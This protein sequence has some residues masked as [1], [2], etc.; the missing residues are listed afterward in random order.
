[1]DYDLYVYNADGGVVIHWQKFE[2]ADDEA[3]IALASELSV[4]APRELWRDQLL[5]KRWETS[6]DCD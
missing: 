3:A 1:M 2:A 5:V 4:Q 6:T